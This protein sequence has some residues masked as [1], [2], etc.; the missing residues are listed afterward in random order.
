MKEPLSV[1]GLQILQSIYLVSAL[2]ICPYLL[3]QGGIYNLYK[4]RKNKFK[5]TFC[6]E[7][8]TREEALFN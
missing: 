6:W 1:N 5:E 4:I 7:M 8:F 2:S 3:S